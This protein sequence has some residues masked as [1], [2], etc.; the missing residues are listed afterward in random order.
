MAHVET[1]SVAK[2]IV[3]ERTN[4]YC[5]S[6]LGGAILNGR[7][8]DLLRMLDA[9]THRMV[10]RMR[11]FLWGETVGEHV[12]SYPADWWQALKDRWFPWWLLRRYPV[13]RTSVRFDVKA[14]YPTLTFQL[15]NEPSSLVLLR[16]YDKDKF[17]A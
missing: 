6:E 9:E 5:Q 4:F 3:L 17:P 16:T 11:G 13:R 10:I 8:V 7:E 2:Q 12:V 1:E 15:P 14:V